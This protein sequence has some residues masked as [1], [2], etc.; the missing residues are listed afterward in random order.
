MNVALNL[1]EK[2]DFGLH[3]IIL[4]LLDEMDF[5]PKK[6]NLVF[7]CH[8]SRCTL[9]EIR[10]IFALCLRNICSMSI[11]H[12]TYAIESH[13]RA[14]VERNCPCSAAIYIVRVTEVCAR[15]FNAV[16]RGTSPTASSLHPAPFVAE[17]RVTR[18]MSWAV[19]I[20]IRRSTETVPRPE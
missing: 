6:K 4:L 15:N 18:F 16:Y 14:F 17:A 11:A 7:L 1:S 13:V 8:Y 20:W 2:K 3:F 12:S 10:A 19:F 5:Q 9:S